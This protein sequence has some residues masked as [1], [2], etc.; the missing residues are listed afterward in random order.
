MAHTT[1]NIMI[2]SSLTSTQNEAEHAVIV[3]TD[4]LRHGGDDVGL[5]PTAMRHVID[6]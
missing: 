1:I 5:G 2:G 6:R 3:G 4:R